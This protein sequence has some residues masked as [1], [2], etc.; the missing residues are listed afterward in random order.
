MATGRRRTQMSRGPKTG[1]EASP[2]YR[3]DEALFR[4][5]LSDVADGVL[6]SERQGN[7]IEVNP[8]GCEM[9]G[10]TLKDLL[11]LSL[12]DLIPA[13][14]LDREPLRLDG[15]RAGEVLLRKGRLLRGDGSLVMAEMST[16][17]LA[18]GRILSL[19][20][21]TS[22]REQIE[23]ELQR[24]NSLLRAIIEA[25][26]VAIIGLDLDG[27]V[28]SAWNPAA[29]RMLG[30]SA[31]E[32]MGRPLPSVPSEKQEEFGRFREQIRRGL[33]LD[34]VAVHRQ[35]R[36]GSPI[37]YKIYASPLRDAAGRII[38]NIA[39]L[40]DTTEHERLEGALAARER[41]YRTLLE[42]LPDLVVRY[43]TNLER[44]YVNPAWE[45]ASGLP[46]EEV[47]NV[48]AADVSGVPRATNESYVRKLRRALET[49]ERQS[50]EFSWT[51]AHGEK[52]FLQY[53]IVPEYDN[54]ETIVGA[55]SVG[56]DLTKRRHLEEKND[57]LAAQFF[58]AQKLESIGR[59]AGGIAHDLNNML[60]P[61][62]GY[63][64]LMLAELGPDSELHDPLTSVKSAAERAADL[65]RQILAFSRQQVLELRL[66]DLNEIVEGF[67]EMIQRLIGEDVELQTLTSPSPF[68]VKAD[69]GQ[70]EQILMNLAV[71]SRDAMP[72]GGKL[73]FEVDT[74]FLDEGYVREHADELTP[75]Q[76]AMLAVSDNG[77]GIEAEAQKRIFEPFYTTKERGKGTGLGL[78]TVFGIVKQHH[79]HIAVYS[80]PGQGTTF[81]IYL[82]RAEETARTTS[83]G[84]NEAL[85]ASGTET[86]LVVDDDDMVRELVCDAL[87]R[88]GYEVVEAETPAEC[89]EL[90]TGM[91]SIHLLLTDVVMPGM[92]GEELG[93][94]I[95]AGH[96]E[97]RVLYM[98]GYTDNVVVRHRILEEDANLLQKPFRVRDLVRKVRTVLDS[99]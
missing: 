87:T 74:A 4:A 84:T 50:I 52:L 42:N 60:V 9:L 28:C 82:P 57:Q 63:T 14:D 23:Q 19:V 88:N 17:R 55:L 8:S 22:S 72:E 10:Y 96:P 64:D 41:E 38:G 79:G 59:L 29:E 95:L 6:I 36:D 7:L 99:A 27:N 45:G 12:A 32:A 78:A 35:R 69:K 75:G 77:V 51:N 43:N 90:A 40:V 11:G 39:V 49:G 18:D 56:R 2:P 46:S 71:N 91:E 13:E 83:A 34:G 44:I 31:E 24:A 65:T 73:T 66:V 68:P 98:S 81:K 21:G 30:W 85:A 15:L 92:S 76:Y 33:T 37:D 61:I 67:R 1:F 94:K 3:V 54:E 86:V 62:L 16:R 20:R 93:K 25:A 58:Q 80:E 48:H 47:V 26:P 53:V 70:I 97:T 5:L 89:L